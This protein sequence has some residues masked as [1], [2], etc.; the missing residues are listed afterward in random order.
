RTLRANLLLL[1]TAFIWG[2][3]FVA[4]DIAMDSLPPFAFN[5]IRMAVAGLVMIPCIA[6]LDRR[7]KIR[8][9]LWA[10]C[11]PPR[12]SHQ[13]HLREERSAYESR[14]VVVGGL[15]C[16]VAL[17]GGS[18]F[19]QLGIRDSTPGKAGFVTTLYIVLVPLAGLLRDRRIRISLW[20]AVALSGIGLFLLCFTDRF[21][22]ATGDLYLVFGAV[23][24]TAH[25]L[26]VDH[27]APRVDCARLSCVQFFIT[28]IL[29][30]PVAAL[31]EQP[32]WQ[33]IWDGFLPIL[34]TGALSGAVG[35]T[36]QM[37]AQRDTS[38]TVASL[39]MCLES[40]FAVLAGWALLG[41]TLTLRELSGCA[42]MMG[43]IVLAQLPWKEKLQV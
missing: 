6:F 2:V 5:G 31:F 17:F 16:G 42:A 20:L 36:L 9:N 40:V 32:T 7:N 23:F 30:L 4:Q 13:R 3:A 25:I 15:C 41:H 21:T 35:Y 34:Y 28:A 37:V 29:C 1:L 12:Q 11:E 22:I 14:L 39:L 43:G 38:P 18:A 19:Q 10:Q 33:G 8:G 24:F 27:F 26:L